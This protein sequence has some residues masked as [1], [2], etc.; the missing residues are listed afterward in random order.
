MTKTLLL[1][2][3]VVV[4]LNVSNLANVVLLLCVR[5]DSNREADKYHNCD[6]C[7]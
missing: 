5:G 3:D 6:K 4:I 1:T 7:Y 2:D